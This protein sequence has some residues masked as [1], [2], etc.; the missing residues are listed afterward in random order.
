MQ[1][2]Q[3]EISQLDRNVTWKGIEFLQNCLNYAV[4]LLL[5]YIELSSLKPEYIFILI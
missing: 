3:L 4:S 1:V 5:K 2:V